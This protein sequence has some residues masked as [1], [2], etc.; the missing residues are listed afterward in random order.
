[1]TS[2]DFTNLA[3]HGRRLNRIVKRLEKRFH[4]EN[5]LDK[6]IKLAN[7]IGFVT[8]EIISISKIH[9]GIGELLENKIEK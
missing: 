5:D 9:L 3:T 1:M 2:T 6:Q 8:R 4:K 7:S